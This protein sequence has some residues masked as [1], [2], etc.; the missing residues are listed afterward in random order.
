MTSETAPPRIGLPGLREW[1]NTLPGSAVREVEQEIGRDLLSD[2]FG[3]HL[4]EVGDV[5][6]PLAE[7]SRVSHRLL[8]ACDGAALPDGDVVA[9]PDLMPIASNAVDVVVLPHVLEFAGNPHGI[10]REAERMLIGEGHILIIGFNPW[11][12]FGL[13]RRT[14]GWRGRAPWCGRWLTPARVRDWLELLGFEVERI[15]RGS[16]RPPLASGDWHARLEFMERLGG[17]F[18]PVASNVYAILARKRVTLLRPVRTSWRL[19]RRLASAGVVEPTARG[20]GALRNFGSR[21]AG[22]G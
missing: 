14:L 9:R 15:M 1:F 7:H 20:A 16:F 21:G 3:Y 2:L 10:L 12:G 8:I 18:W 22:D 11:S 5:G 19:R 4:V 13:C 6:A 17:H